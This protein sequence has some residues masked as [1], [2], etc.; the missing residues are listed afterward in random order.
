MKITP[1]LARTIV[2]YALNSP[3]DSAIPSSP[4]EMMF[5]ILAGGTPRRDSASASG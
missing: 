1:C 3:N 2:C 5:S 4:L